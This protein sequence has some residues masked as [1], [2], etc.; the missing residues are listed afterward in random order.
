MRASEM[1]HCQ[2]ATGLANAY[3]GLIVLK[4]PQCHRLVTNGLEEVQDKRPLGAQTESGSHNLS[5][6]RA[7]TYSSSFF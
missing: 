4:E 1:S 7:V 2:I 3:H 5:L 6:G